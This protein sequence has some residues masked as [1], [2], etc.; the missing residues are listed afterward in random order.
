MNNLENTDPFMVWNDPM[1]RDDPFSPHND[2]MKSDDPFKPWNDPLGSEDDLT[3][4]EK[5]DYGLK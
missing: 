3:D 2:P 5:E 4:D 1:Y